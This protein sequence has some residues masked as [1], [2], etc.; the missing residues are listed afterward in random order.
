[1]LHGNMHFL[2][3]FYYKQRP[4][5]FLWAP[6]FVGLGIALYFALPLEPV[7]IL[8]ISISVF[9]F[10]LVATLAAYFQKE[11][12]AKWDVIWLLALALLWASAGF[13]ASQYRTDSVSTPMLQRD[14]RITEVSGR[15]IDFDY[16][17]TEESAILVLDLVTIEKLKP[18]E[19]PRKI[20]LTAKQAGTVKVGDTIT[21]LAGLHPPS[22]PLYP[23]GYDF[24]RHFYFKGIGA[25]GFSFKPP[26]ITAS[27]T[28]QNGFFEGARNH[29]SKRVHDLLKSTYAS[30]TVAFMTGERAG[31]E[32]SDWKALRESGLAHLMAISGMNIGLVAGIVFYLVR[33]MLALFPPLALNLPI[34]KIACV[35]AF[36]A[37]ALYTFLVNTPI[38]AE[39]ALIMTGFALLAIMLDRNPFSL[40]MVAIAA[41][42]VL[43]TTPEAL[44]G[45]SFQMSF[46][47][48][49]VLIAYIEY[50]Q[51]HKKPRQTQP[52][53]FA[54]FIIALFWILITSLLATAATAP[55]SLYNFQQFSVSGIIANLLAIPLS[56]FVTMPFTLLT[57]LTMPIGGDRP[58][59]LITHWSIETMMAIAHWAA[60]WPYGV[61]R[62]HAWPTL[63]LVLFVGGGLWLVI[64]AGRA[65]LLG[66]VP[67][68][69]A[70]IPFML[71]QPPDILV[72]AEG[73]LAAIKTEQ[74]M[75][76]NNGRTESFTRKLW[77]Q[78]WGLDET[79]FDIFKKSDALKCD[80]QAC[81][82]KAEGKTVS[83]V[84]DL[85]VLPE[86]KA[87]ADIA[88]PL[89]K[90]PPQ[91]YS[92]AWAIWLKDGQQE[93]AFPAQTRPWTR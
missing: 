64:I 69:L 16:G 31:M 6:V 54:K 74:G 47:A 29:I 57:Y 86:E 56:S 55:F 61:V 50:W 22:G 30:I 62:T 11:Q 2:G 63:S 15:V 89:N 83:F 51:T 10:A 8:S 20:R 93:Y 37:A 76:V 46:A 3:E 39:R 91:W 26:V 13:I 78:Y 14:I 66:F 32:E 36:I 5:A 34:K 4:N 45:T 92:G 84:S 44:L 90:R 1:M 18:E 85:T 53:F 48:V 43:L 7:Y 9:A 19:T 72:D 67:V 42:I 65:R 41:V 35:P 73:K 71:Y 21:A 75:I 81:R 25:I 23:G 24:R 40:R 60:N 82:Y 58:F 77:S 38:P 87:G 70:I 52:N 49:M 28:I 80:A 27:T 12:N 68:A 59:I 17:E 33:F 88:V 79:E